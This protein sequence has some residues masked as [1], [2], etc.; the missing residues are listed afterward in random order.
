[1]QGIAETEIKYEKNYSR[2]LNLY[3]QVIKEFGQSED[4][5]KYVQTVLDNSQKA[6]ISLFDESDGTQREQEKVQKDFQKMTET[7]PHF[8]GT[9]AVEMYMKTDLI[10]VKTAMILCTA[11][12]AVYVAVLCR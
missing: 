11:Q 6:G 9:Y 10:F 4:Y 8:L 12:R 1:M 7:K 5:P 3:G 2:E